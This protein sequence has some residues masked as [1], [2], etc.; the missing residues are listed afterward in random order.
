MNFPM[1]GLILRR[2]I[3]Q[4][5]SFNILGG[6]CKSRRESDCRLQRGLGTREAGEKYSAHAVSMDFK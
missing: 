6:L 5:G 4:E 2:N 3:F 1:K